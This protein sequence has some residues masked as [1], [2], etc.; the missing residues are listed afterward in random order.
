MSDINVMDQINVVEE[1]NI[2]QRLTKEFLEH[3]KASD[4][5]IKEFRDKNKIPDFV[6]IWGV[7]VSK[8]R[9]FSRMLAKVYKGYDFP[10]FF[11]LVEILW[12]PDSSLEE[13][14]LALLLLQSRKKDLSE[15]DV[16]L[17]LW[18]WLWGNF[19]E[20]VHDWS[21]TE[22]IAGSIGYQIIETWQAIDDEET[23]QII[24]DSLKDKAADERN[25]P[26]GKIFSVL[27]PVKRIQKLG[28]S[29]VLPSLE[30]ILSAIA[31]F[32]VE[33]K[34]IGDVMERTIILT[35]RECAKTDSAIVMEFLKKYYKIGRFYR[36]KAVKL[37]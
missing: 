32:E 2:A 20:N 22:L 1:L 16:C 14:Y 3:E 9:Q 28:Q 17:D 31:K 18:N 23:N 35:M 34:E 29:A 7:D 30:V 15:V 33:E 19:K 11:K 27:C 26:F 8:L 24:W 5:E 10:R 13:H 6:E 21:L 4:V 36:K 37:G 25:G 12:V